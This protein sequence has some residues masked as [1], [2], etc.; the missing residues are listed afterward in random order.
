[1]TTVEA[2][3]PL[4]SRG[5]AWAR[6]VSATALRVGLSA[7]AI[8]VLSLAF[9]ALGVLALFHTARPWNVLLLALGIQLRLLCNL[10][11]GMVAV[12]GGR[13]SVYGAL[14]NEVPDRI[15]DSAF[16]IAL[17]Y[18]I[19]LP[20]LGWFGAL[21]AAVT[22]YIRVLGGTLG[23]AQDFRGPMA[24]PHRMATLTV[25][26]F[27][28]MAEHLWRGSQQVLV[29]AAWLIAVGGVITCATRLRAIASKMRSA[30]I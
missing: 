14:Y 4:T 26:C 5:S 24:K 6:A 8:S 15:A 20:W 7:D 9:T 1:M 30:V 2:R 18:Y 22:A 17:G 21:A 19:D 3:R 23:L 16:L 28:A 12:E 10:I 25:A 29:L 27:L 13:K 11:D